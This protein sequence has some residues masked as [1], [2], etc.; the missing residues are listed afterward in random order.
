MSGIGWLSSTEPNLYDS[1][2]REIAV[3]EARDSLAEVIE[4]TQ[5]TG[6]AVAV[7]RRGRRVAVLM[8][9]N[10]Y[11]RITSSLEDAVDRALLQ[12]ARDEDDFIPWEQAKRD[13]GLA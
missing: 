13:L 3:S 7:T 2:M 10:E 6:K 12:L 11:D 1:Y 5:R 8:D 4:E 9:A